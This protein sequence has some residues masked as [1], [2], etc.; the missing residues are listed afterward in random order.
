MVG[1]DTH[2]FFLALHCEIT[3]SREDIFRALQQYF[4]SS[5]YSQD[6][7][8]HSAANKARLRCFIGEASENVIKEMIL[9]RPK[10]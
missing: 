8:L 3:V 5:N 7:T 6:H 2:S 1:G 9:L 10:I 4:D